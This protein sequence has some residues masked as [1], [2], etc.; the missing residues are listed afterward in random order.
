MI[1]FQQNVKQ[2]GRASGE[3]GVRPIDRPP[4]D[5]KVGAVNGCRLN[6]EEQ[7]RQTGVVYGMLRE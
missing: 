5:R 6:F 1:I 3:T 2:T 7:S 4:E